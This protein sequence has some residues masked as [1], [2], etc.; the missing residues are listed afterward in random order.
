MPSEQETDAVDRLAWGLGMIGA[1][2]M[3]GA[4]GLIALLLWLV[5]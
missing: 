4:V 1:A 5:L 2:G 3:I